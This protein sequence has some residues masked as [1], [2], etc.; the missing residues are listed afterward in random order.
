MRLNQYLN[1][2]TGKTSVEEII[3]LLY[4]ECK[5][6]LKDT[7]KNNKINFMYSGRKDNRDVFRGVP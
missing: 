7:L 2:S 1:E 4:D 5:P 3:N 6:Y